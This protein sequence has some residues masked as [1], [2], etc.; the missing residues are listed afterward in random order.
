MRRIFYILIAIAIYLVLSYLPGVNILTK[1][2]GILCTFLHEFGHAF[3]AIISGGSVHSLAVNVDESGV[4]TTSG[5]S[6][7]LITMGGYVGSAVFGN[8]MIRFSTEKMSGNILKILCILML[9]TAMFLYSNLITTGMLV[10]FALA[11]Y[12]LSGK[13]ISPFILSFLGVA[14]VVYIIQDFNVGPTSD[15][16]AYEQEVGL[17]PAAVWMYIWLAIVLVMTGWNMINLFKVKK[18]D[19]HSVRFNKI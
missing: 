1:P 4:T 19:N 12:F 13:R 17:F 8:L 6:P 14:S 16:Q 18:N 2:V 15:L 9:I 3:F 5:G 7:G 11:L 10:V